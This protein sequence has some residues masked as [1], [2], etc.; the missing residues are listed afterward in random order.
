MF[1]STRSHC[2]FPS[3]MLSL[4]EPHFWQDGVLLRPMGITEAER[5]GRQLFL[6]KKL[7]L[8]F[9]FWLPGNLPPRMRCV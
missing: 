4:F 3:E 5:E 7:M 2:V 9:L 6:T 8:E 1:C